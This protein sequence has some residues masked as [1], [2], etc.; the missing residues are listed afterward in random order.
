MAFKAFCDEYCID[1]QLT[2]SYN[3]K[4]SGATERGVGLVKAIMKKT[5]EEGSC[6]EEALAAFKN[7]RNESGCPLEEI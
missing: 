1:L 6:L 7:L 2:S 5:E 4:S 3:P